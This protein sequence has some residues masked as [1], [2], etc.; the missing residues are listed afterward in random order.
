MFECRLV[1]EVYCCLFL[2][3]FVVFSVAVD[4][5]SFIIVGTPR[6]VEDPVGLGTGGLGSSSFRM[7]GTKRFEDPVGSSPGELGSSSFQLYGTK[8]VED[9]RIVESW[10]LRLVSSRLARILQ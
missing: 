4:F 5:V 10:I 1:F 9:P 8:R 3:V 2:F 6:Y 7:Y